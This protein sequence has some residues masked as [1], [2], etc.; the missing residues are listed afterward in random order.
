MPAVLRHPASV[1]SGRVKTPNDGLWHLH[2][3]VRN[4]SDFAADA[5]GFCLSREGR[6]SSAAS[7]GVWGWPQLGEREGQS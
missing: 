1:N 7:V 4:R 3:E 5:S 2:S 6:A